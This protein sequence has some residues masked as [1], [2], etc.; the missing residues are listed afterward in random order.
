MLSRRTLLKGTSA[1]FGY[2]AF[3]ALANEQAA[4]AAEPTSPLSP[5]KS[6]FPAKAKRVIFLCMDGGPSH[7]DTFDHKPRL[8]ADDGKP[9]PARAGGF[10]R[11]GKLL[12]SPFKFAPRG[13]SGLYVSDALPELAKQ[14]DELCVLNGMYCDLP[15]H[16]QAFIQMHCGIFQF[17]R[18]SM[19][20]WVVYGLGTENAN[21][22]G[23]ITLS[24][25]GG[26]GGPVNYGSSF[27]PAVYQ[28]TRI[29]RGGFGGG[30][31][32]AGA[33]QVP[34]LKNPKQTADQQR[35]ELDF[36]QSL[37][38]NAQDELGGDAGIEGLIGSYELAFRMQA[39]MPKL[40]DLSKETAATL[41]L[42]GADGGGGGGG[43][44]GPG[45]GGG[46]PGGFGRQCLLAR[47][48]L[49]AGVR[50]VEVTMG[51]WDHHRTIK[52]SLANSCNAIDKPIAG[53]LQDLKQR[54]MLKDT[55]VLWGGE[56]GRTP[57]SQGDGRDH[58]SRGYSMWMAGGGVKAGFAHGKTDDHG[59]EAI[60]GKVHVHDWHATVL[61]L[62]GLDHEKLT[63]RHAGRDMRLTDV[64]GN[65][66]KEVMA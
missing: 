33:Q 16:P 42:Y 1:G 43:G 31:G 19:G 37:N 2:L 60:D 18:P 17:P 4:R 36:L 34:N 9:A 10:G 15:N 29:G 7:V 3:A 38:Q 6:H 54:D 25:S 5:R 13:K 12:G 47:R 58:N 35:V 40:M 63:Y 65:V 27:L 59:F 11:G 57:T 45:G 32:G 62:L 41:K 20:A 26:N 28:G 46:G 49:E 22:P 23:F 44:F 66:V 48:F 64:K 39:E 55:L 24:P 51:G 53:L 30:P 61:H 14:A 21:L 52:D 50:F 56:F 8:T